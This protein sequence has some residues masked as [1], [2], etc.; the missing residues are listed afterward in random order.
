MCV[1]DCTKWSPK[2]I[3]VEILQCVYDL[4]KYIT[5]F[6]ILFV[7]FMQPGTSDVIK[8]QK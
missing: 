4:L 1:K 8:T 2:D 7:F 5:K 6:Q 3:S